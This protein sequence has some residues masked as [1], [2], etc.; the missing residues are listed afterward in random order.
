L[1]KRHG[2]GQLLH[3]GQVRILAVAPA[4]SEDVLHGLAREQV[5]ELVD[6]VFAAPPHELAQQRLVRFDPA[7]LEHPGPHRHTPRFAVDESSVEVEQGRARRRPLA[8]GCPQAHRNSNSPRLTSP[9]TGRE[10]TSPS[11]SKATIGTNRETLLATTTAGFHLI[12]CRPA[13]TSSPWAARSLNPRIRGSRT[14]FMPRCT[15]TPLPSALCTTNAC[16]WKLTIRPVIGATASCTSLRGSIAVPGPTNPWANIGSGT[17]LSPTATPVTGAST[18]STLLPPSP[19]RALS[20][21]GK[22]PGLARCRGSQAE[23]RTE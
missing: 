23:L 2:P 19:T 10:L 14:V 21:G 4:V 3:R 16:G 22:P 7:V 15:R 9:L 5:G 17:L 12:S 6:H 11:A 13:V 1:Q 8:L 18:A 20:D